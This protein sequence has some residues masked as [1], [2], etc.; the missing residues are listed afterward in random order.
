M[1]VSRATNT[2]IEVTGSAP[3]RRL[4]ADGLHALY[5]GKD[6]YHCAT[7]GQEHTLGLIAESDGDGARQ[8]LVVIRDE[9]EA[10]IIAE[11]LIVEA[12]GAVSPGAWLAMRTLAAVDASDPHD[13]GAMN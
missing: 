11:Y 3:L 8:G 12:F 1:A 6:A 2:G 10:W 5:G 9:E 7:C 13:D 4:V